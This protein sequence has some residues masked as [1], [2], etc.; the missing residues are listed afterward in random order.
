MITLLANDAEK[1]IHVKI[2]TLSDE[3]CNLDQ[4][5]MRP[6]SFVAAAHLHFKQNYQPCGNCLAPAEKKSE[7]PVEEARGS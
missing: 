3:R 4:A 5:H 6:I 1:T 2:G 7:A